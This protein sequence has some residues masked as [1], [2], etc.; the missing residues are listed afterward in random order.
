MLTRETG[1]LSLLAKPML[2]IRV[3]A[4]Y[5]HVM[6]TLKTRPLPELVARLGSP[7][8][9][10]RHHHPPRRVA[11]AVHALLRIGDRRPR[12]LIGALVL[13]RLLKEQGDPAV[14]VIGLPDEGEDP[15]AH[16]WVEIGGWDLGPPPGKGHHVEMVKYV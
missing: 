16:A 4:V 1:S 12:C 11:T 9:K 10:A 8:R 15:T 3:Y 7:R 14:L 2:A 13:F 6:A 5:L